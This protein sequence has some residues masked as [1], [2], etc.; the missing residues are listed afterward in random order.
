MV[1]LVF[2]H[3]QHN[4]KKMRNNIEKSNESGKPRCL[5]IKGKTVTWKKLKDAYK[6][7]TKAASAS[8]FMRNSRHNILIWTRLPKC[9]TTWQRTF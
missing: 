6:I 7:G 1:F 9:E 4:I 5:K 3:Y 2:S 8:P